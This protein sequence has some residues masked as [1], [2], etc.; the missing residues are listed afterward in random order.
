MEGKKPMLPPAEA[1]L[2]GW[3]MFRRD[4]CSSGIQL[5]CSLVRV[6]TVGQCNATEV[7]GKVLALC[8]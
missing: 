1:Q 7:P 3:C 8:E 4:A 6:N 5:R 2:D